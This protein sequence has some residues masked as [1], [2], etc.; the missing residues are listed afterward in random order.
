[1]IKFSVIIE[2]PRE[3]GIGSVV[4]FEGKSIAINK[5][6]KIEPITE[7]TFLVSGS[8]KGLK[9]RGVNE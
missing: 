8:G 1:M 4:V 7:K 5:I 3:M 6:T 9:R 2:Y